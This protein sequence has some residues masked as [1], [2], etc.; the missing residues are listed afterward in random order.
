MFSEYGYWRTVVLFSQMLVSISAF[1]R[2]SAAVAAAVVSGVAGEGGELVAGDDGVGA[3]VGPWPAA[4]PE[5]PGVTLS[6]PLGA[7]GSSDDEQPAA[8]AQS[9]P[10]VKILTRALETI[11]GGT[12]FTCSL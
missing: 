8:T 12:F 3:V 1:F 6:G 11:R 10:S 9:A 4:P 7:V 2:W 5:L